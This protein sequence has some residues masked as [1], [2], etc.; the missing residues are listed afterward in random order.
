M[1]KGGESGR[2]EGKREVDGRRRKGGREDGKAHKKEINYFKT[3][4]SLTT[5]LR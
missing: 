5:P 2:K 3:A 1:R 4:F